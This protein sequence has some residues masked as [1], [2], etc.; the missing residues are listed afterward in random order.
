MRQRKGKIISFYF[1]LLIVISTI[2]NF[3]FNNISFNKV[4]N[5]KV[6]GLSDANN[7]IISKKLI[8]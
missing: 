8:I 6:S 7:K 4:K 3:S 5:I 2:T 1:F